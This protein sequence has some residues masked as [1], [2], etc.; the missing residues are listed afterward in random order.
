MMYYSLV[1][2]RTP[3]S[4]AGDSTRVATLDRYKQLREKRI[5]TVAI[6][7]ELG[8]KRVTLYRW[9]KDETKER[10]QEPD[11]YLSPNAH[12]HVADVNQQFD[13][14]T[15]SV[16]PSVSAPQKEALNANTN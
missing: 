5:P 9:L 14:S 10:A 3:H 6:C 13:D 15:A 7:E 16:M 2:Q 4:K 11:R 12:P 8:I 1:A